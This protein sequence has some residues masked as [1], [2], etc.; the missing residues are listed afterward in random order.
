MTGDWVRDFYSPLD[1]GLIAALCVSIIRRLRYYRSLRQL[2][3]AAAIVLC[4][5]G[6]PQ[7]VSRKLLYISSQNIDRFSKFFTFTFCGKFVIKW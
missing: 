7:K 3:A 2:P 4:I 1:G 6:G 5:Q